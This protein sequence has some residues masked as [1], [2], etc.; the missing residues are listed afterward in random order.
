MSR[1]LRSSPVG[2]RYF[3]RSR[4]YGFESYAWIEYSR[5]SLFQQNGRLREAEAFE[6]YETSLLVSETASCDDFGS[7]RYRVR[8]CA[9]R[10]RDALP[11]ECLITEVRGEHKN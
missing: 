2:A 7:M 1:V 6:R 10:R 5:G 8:Q 4:G 9:C 3:S 11:N